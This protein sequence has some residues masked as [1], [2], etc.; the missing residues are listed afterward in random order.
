M[1]GILNPCPD[2]RGEIRGWEDPL[3]RERRPCA[4]GGG[5]R[6]DLVRTFAS[7]LWGRGVR[8]EGGRKEGL[9]GS[10]TGPCLR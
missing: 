3:P 8:G 2:S 4:P 9:K 5:G 7:G 6:G 10:L 1:H